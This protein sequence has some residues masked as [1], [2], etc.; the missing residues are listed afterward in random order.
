VI[1]KLNQLNNYLDEFRNYKQGDEKYGDYL[2]NKY[3]I[4]NWFIDGICYLPQH[5]QDKLEFNIDRDYEEIHKKSMAIKEILGDI[6]GYDKDK[7]NKSDLKK[8]EQLAFEFRKD[9]KSYEIKIKTIINIYNEK[10]QKFSKS[11]F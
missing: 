5:I 2:Y 7:I 8:I 9:Y 1:A 6:S 10:N 11:I 4:L 3:A